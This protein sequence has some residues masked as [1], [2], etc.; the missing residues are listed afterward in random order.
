VE[1]LSNSLANNQASN[2][3]YTDFSDEQAYLDEI[4]DSIV[5]LDDSAIQSTMAGSSCGQR[6]RSLTDLV[7]KKKKSQVAQKGS[8]KL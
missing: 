5:D 6:G 7:R 1:E 2:R 8:V 3:K 4:G